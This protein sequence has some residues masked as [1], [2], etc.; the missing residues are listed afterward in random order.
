MCNTRTTLVSLLAVAVMVPMALSVILKV[1]EN[2]PYIYFTDVGN[3][4]N[5]IFFVKA[6]RNAKIG[7]FFNKSDSGVIYEVTLGAGINSYTVLRNFTTGPL[8]EHKH[9]IHLDCNKFRPFWLDWFNQSLTMGSGTVLG[10]ETMFTYKDP[11]QKR[12][13][14]LALSTWGEFEGNWMLTSSCRKLPSVQ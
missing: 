6:C 9:G 3:K 10:L 13:R 12:T 8:I 4:T 2:S 14:F 5:W 11:L 7:L 1:P